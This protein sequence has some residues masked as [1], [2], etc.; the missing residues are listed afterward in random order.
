IKEMKEDGYQVEQLGFEKEIRDYKRRLK[1]CV[2]S[3]EKTGITDAQQIIAEIEERISEIYLE[4]EKEAIAKTYIETQYP[5]YENELEQLEK[6]F[7]ETKNEV[8]DLKQAYYIEDNDME[9]FL[10]LEKSIN[11]LT[12]QLEEVLHSIEN[13]DTTHTF[14]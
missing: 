12:N 14:V 7:Q 10:S 13:E 11:M 5:N 2:K 3:I 6:N 8:D 9:Q 4:L 1:D